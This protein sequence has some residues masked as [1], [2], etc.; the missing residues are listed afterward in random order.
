MRSKRICKIDMSALA[1]IL[2]V[3]IFVMWLADEMY[4]HSRSGS[5]YLAKVDKPTPMRKVMKEDAM[6]VSIARDGNVYFGS[7]KVR[8]EALLAGISESVRNGSERKVYIQADARA[9]YVNVKDV[10]DVV[11]DAGIQNVAFIVEQRKPGQ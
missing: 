3:L 5:L 10:I 6:I 2:M 7:F 1:A 4:G 9:R 11:R 8:P